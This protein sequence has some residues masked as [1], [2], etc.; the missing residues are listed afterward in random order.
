VSTADWIV[1][2]IVLL[3]AVIGFA[4][5]LVRGLL[6]LAGLALG[7]YVGARLAPA[8]LSHGSPYAPLVALAGAVLGGSLLQAVAGVAAAPI[9]ASMRAIPG[10][11]TLDSVA[12]FLLGAVAGFFVAWVVGAVLLYVPG[13][14]GLRHAVQRSAILSRINDRFP[15]ERLVG[16]LE[17][18]DP[19]GVIF[20]PSAVV[21]APDSKLARDPDVVAAAASVVRVTGF[22]C[23]LG[24]EGSGWIVRPELVVTNAHVVAGVDRPR[25]DRQDGPGEAATVV[26][27]D[28]KDDLALLRVPGLE[29]KP[30]QLADPDRGAPI[31]IVGYPENGPRSRVPGRLGETAKALSRDAYG[32]GPVT[33]TVTTLRGVVRP[34]NSGGPGVDARGR[35]RTTVFA[36]RAGDTGGYG[37]PAELVR[38]VLNDAGT[39][40]VGATDCAQ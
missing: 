16:T 14:S 35:V 8:V 7:A 3:A 33:R 34:G 31:A 28:V 19:F 1:L 22:A 24:V 4:R 10:L 15:P 11:R 39:S 36:R 38:K 9:R 30:L 40:S 37:I 5:G 20:G 2:V 21:P 32:H 23:G 29:G 12:G 13:Q 6:S 18:V 27:F 25:V 26:A 17:R